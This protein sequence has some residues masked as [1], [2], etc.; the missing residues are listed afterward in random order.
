MDKLNHPIIS[1]RY[2]FPRPGQPEPYHDFRGID[3]ARLR[4]HHRKAHPEARTLVHF[5]GNGE[6]VADYLGEYADAIVSMG[7]NLLLVEYRGYGGSEGETRFGQMLQDVQCVREQCG[8]ASSEVILYGRSVGAI[9]AVEWVHQDPAVAGL[10]LESGVAD[11]GQRL[12]LRLHPE[13]LGLDPDQFG[14]LCQR[15][16]DH[17]T[18]L[19]G[20]CGPVLILHA[21]H[22]SLVQAEHARAHYEWCPG[23]NKELV[24]FPRGDHNSVLALNH[25]E[26]FLHLARFINSLNS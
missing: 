13:E 10:I 6:I 3:G 4:C 25:S 19:A 5:H 20:Y 23:E 14:A 1:E 18:K 17:Q 12:L 11:P 8:L 7:V 2:F 22:D 24:L 26:Y 21:E 9:F 15:Y 16:L